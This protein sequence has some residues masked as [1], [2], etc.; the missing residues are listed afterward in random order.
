MKGN[1]KTGKFGI[2]RSSR[3][4]ASRFEEVYNGW[5]VSFFL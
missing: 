1:L 4:F 3:F 5:A 2:R